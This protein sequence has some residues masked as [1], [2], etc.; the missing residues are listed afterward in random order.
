MKRSNQTFIYLHDNVK[1]MENREPEK[2]QTNRVKHVGM[3][4]LLLLSMV[5][6]ATSGATLTGYA[7]LGN[8]YAEGSLF[9]VVMG[10]VSLAGS[11]LI[12][13]LIER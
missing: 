8:L 10:F 3:Y 11:F 13:F 7:T 4:F 2:V 5:F 1:I 12:Y 6:F 9:P